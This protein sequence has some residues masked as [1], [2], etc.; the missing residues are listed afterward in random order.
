MAPRGSEKTRGFGAACGLAARL[1]ALHAR[2]KRVSALWGCVREAEAAARSHRHT[3][4]LSWAGRQDWTATHAMAQEVGMEGGHLR[5]PLELWPWRNGPCRGGP[6]C[7]SGDHPHCSPCRQRSKER[8]WLRA[9]RQAALHPSTTAHTPPARAASRAEHRECARFSSPGRR[10]RAPAGRGRGVGPRFK[11]NLGT[12]RQ[13]IDNL[14]SYILQSV[15]SGQGEGGQG[16]WDRGEGGGEKSGAVR[17]GQGLQGQVGHAGAEG[18]R[19]RAR[20]RR[21][22]PTLPSWPCRRPFSDFRPVSQ[23]PT[24]LR[25]IC[26]GRWR[27]VCG[28][29]EVPPSS[30]P[31]AQGTGGQGTCTLAAVDRRGTRVL[32]PIDRPCSSVL[33]VRRSY[34]TFVSASLWASA[35]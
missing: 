9:G 1:G 14:Q 20:G 18:P 10:A 23:T 27:G 15:I 26:G 16:G 30:G 7:C 19:L 3:Q 24:H 28:P 8:W 4:E 13:L 22:V 6:A 33:A 31:G 21:R 11:C 2:C 25:W 35:I 5:L 32:R 34:G 17:D 29:G 12:F